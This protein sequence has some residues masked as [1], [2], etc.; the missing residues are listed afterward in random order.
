MSI[1]DYSDLF[2]QCGEYTGRDDFGHMFPRFVSYAENK[3]NRQL[4]VGGM[5][6]STTITTATDG[7]VALP[8]DYLEMR[9]VKRSTGYVMDLL[10]PNAADWQ[11][12][13]HSGTPHAYAVIG[14][15]FHVK[16]YASETFSIIYYAKIDP[17]TVSNT[18]NWLLT[19]APLIYLYFV[20]AEIVGW[21][22]ATGKEGSSEKL[23]A[24]QAVAASELQT[25]QAEDARR[26]FSNARVMVR[27]VNP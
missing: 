10:T 5:E 17:L 23:A 13:S 24:A 7:T 25:Y 22:L 8:A 1:A 14:S 12:G 15:T 20:C 18:T 9:Q 4:R 27:G 6:T 19:D 3:L 21:A 26:R 11:Y 16:P 2:V